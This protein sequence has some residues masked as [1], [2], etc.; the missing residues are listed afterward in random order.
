MV[1]KTAFFMKIDLAP[2][3]N[4][5]AAEGAQSC[6]K[7]SGTAEDGKIIEE[8]SLPPSRAGKSLKKQGFAPPKAVQTLKKV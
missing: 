5:G 2:F 1:K 6:Q 4:F 7:Q 3:S 8:K